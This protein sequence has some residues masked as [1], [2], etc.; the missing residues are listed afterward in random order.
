MFYFAGSFSETEV[1]QP[2]I[3]GEGVTESSYH[4]AKR[5]KTHHGR[6]ECIV[7]ECHTSVPSWSSLLLSN[8]RQALLCSRLR[9]WRRGNITCLFLN[10]ALP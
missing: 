10:I 7:E 6:A 8:S 5:S 1:R 4:E 2:T 3:R 9:E